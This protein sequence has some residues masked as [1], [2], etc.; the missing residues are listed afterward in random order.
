MIIVIISLIF[1][2]AYIANQE[3]LAIFAVSDFVS[4]VFIPSGVR[5][6]AV[7]VYKE[8]GAFGVFFGSLLIS[9][10]Y[11]GQTNVELAVCAALVS[12]GSALLSRMLCGRWMNLEEN[13]RGISFSQVAQICVVFSLMSAT[14]H[15]A[16]YKLFGVSPDFL[17]HTFYMFVGD[18]SGAFIVIASAKFFFVLRQHLR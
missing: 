17:L 11:L 12:S 9:F 3:L 10:A 1:A 14:M 15:Q 8:I 6:F 18:V 4:L 16:L 13:L 5:I 7:L 2:A